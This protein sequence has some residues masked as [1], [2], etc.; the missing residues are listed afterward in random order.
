MKRLLVKGISATILVAAL[1]FPPVTSVFAVSPGTQ[2]QPGQ[3]CLSSTAPQ[4]PGKHPV[5]L[6]QHLMRRAQEQLALSTPA[7]AY[8]LRQPIAPM[9]SLSMMWP[10]SRC[11]NPIR[12]TR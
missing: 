2:G 12:S 1:A 3:T 4:E 11:H 9:L 8:Q 6:D 7:T 5:L 10:A